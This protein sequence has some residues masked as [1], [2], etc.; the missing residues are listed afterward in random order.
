MAGHLASPAD[1]RDLRHEGSGNPGALNAAGVLGWRWGLAVLGADVGKGAVAGIFGR[2]IGGDHGGYAAATTAIAGHILPPWSRFRG[3]KGVATSAG[4][5]LAVFPAYFPVDA[6]VAAMSSITSRDTTTTIRW[7]CAAWTAAA[8]L[9]WRRAL[10]NA[11][12][13]APG[14]ALPAFAAASSLLILARVA[15]RSSR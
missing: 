13:P 4:A 15:L 2:V 11:W 9:W 8:L 6:C 1:P 3:G 12:G 14:P 7:S 5:C 10:P